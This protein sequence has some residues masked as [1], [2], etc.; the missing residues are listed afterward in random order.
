MI[1]ST[2]ACC[3][4]RLGQMPVE[5]VHC[6]ACGRLLCGAECFVAHAIAAVD[7]REHARSFPSA[8][9]LVLAPPE[10]VGVS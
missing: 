6:E 3:G 5:I 1:A 4:R 9:R 10:R 7:D 2:C 8:R